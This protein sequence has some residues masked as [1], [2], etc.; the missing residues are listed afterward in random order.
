MFLAMIIYIF[1]ANRLASS[2]MNPLKFNI[3]TA[4]IGVGVA[5]FLFYTGYASCN[6]FIYILVS[7]FLFWAV[8]IIMYSNKQRIVSINIKRER[9][10]ADR[11][12]WILYILYI[13]LTLFS[14]KQFGVPIFNDDSRLAVYVNSGGFGIIQ[15]LQSVMNTYS[16]FYLLCLYYDHRCTRLKLLLLLFP[17]VIIG[18]LSG[19]RSSFLVFIFAYWGIKTFYFGDEPKLAKYK[20]LLIP[21]VAISVI[22]FFM[23]SGNFTLAITSFVERV[24][25]CGDLYWQALPDESWKS[26]EVKEP[27]RFVFMGLLGPLRILDAS[28]ME[29]PIGYQLTDLTYPGLNKMTGPVALFPVGSLIF[30]GY[31]GGLFFTLIQAFLAALAYRL[32]YVK[33]N[34]VI[35][36]AVCYYM[37]VELMPWLGDAS[38][39]MGAVFNILLNLFFVTILLLMIALFNCSSKVNNDV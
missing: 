9:F 7:S 3:L 17:L 34:S 11:L 1:I 16:I 8:F 29:V 12:F 25:A 23:Q 24:I 35:I 36:C 39:G 18:V 10:F 33:S 14:Y 19:S 13:S 5:I 32:I 26:V 15:R 2:W 30:F 20:S 27:I 21:F 28:Q 31:V 22:T 6:T 4:G 38:A 37:F